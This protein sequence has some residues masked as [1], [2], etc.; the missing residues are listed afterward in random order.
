MRLRHGIPSSLHQKWEAERARIRTLP[1]GTKSDVDLGRESGIDAGLINDERRALGIP[2]YR[3]PKTMCS[4]EGCDTQHISRHLC[5][6]HYSAWR[7]YGDPLRADRR[8][9]TF[10]DRMASLFRRVRP[11]LASNP[12]QY[13]ADH[14]GV[15]RWEIERLRR[16]WGAP[17]IGCLRPVV[18]PC[19]KYAVLKMNGMYCSANC[20]GV[21]ERA[22]R[23]MNVS[24]ATAAMMLPSLLAMN[25]ARAELRRHGKT[26]ALS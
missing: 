20:R 17:A 11:F 18:C 5:I 22:S 12:D 3:K 16:E 10:A 23:Q 19:G 1:L 7:M 2:A 9:A 6:R 4:V 25:A 24:K 13:I 14:F 26:G 8:R 15:D 21:A